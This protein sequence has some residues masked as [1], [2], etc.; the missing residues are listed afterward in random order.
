MLLHH[1]FGE[2]NGKRGAWGHALGGMGAITQAM[3]EAAQARGARIRTGAR[4]ARLSMRDGAASG[5]VLASGEEIAARAVAAN[6]PP[7]LLFRDL[8]PAEAL[9]P[10]LRDRFLAM[11]SGSGTFRMNVA[12]AELPDFTCRPGKHAA[13]PP[14][15]G[16]RHR[17]DARLSGARLSSTRALT[18]GRPS[19]SSRC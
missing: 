5:V 15:R 9:A 13:R 18:A 3:A 12:L 2:V 16:H 11:K 7:K 14:R 8:V 6:M 4:V 19:R 1:C 10:E 17:A